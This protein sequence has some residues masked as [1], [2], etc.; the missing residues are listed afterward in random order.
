MLTDVMNGFRDLV[1]SNALN[2]LYRA[3]RMKDAESVLAMI[4]EKFHENPNNPQ[5]FY[6]MS[7]GFIAA[8]YYKDAQLMIEKS[9]LLDPNEPWMSIVKQYV[10]LIACHHL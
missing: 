8:A 1:L 7:L 10:R 9:A 3:E 4:E 6:S 5:V 2:I